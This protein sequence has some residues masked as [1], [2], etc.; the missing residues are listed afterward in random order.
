[1]FNRLNNDGFAIERAAKKSWPWFALALVVGFYQLPAFVGAMWPPRDIISD[2]YQD[3]ASARNFFCG[4]P[5]YSDNREMVGRYVGQVDPVCLCNPVNAHPPTSVLLFA[6]LARLDYR[7]ALLIWNLSSLALLGLSLRL[8]FQGLGVPFSHRTALATFCLLMFCRPL[9]QQLFHGQLNLVLLAL[10]TGA[11]AA[12]RSGRAGW[13]GALVG[14]ATAIKLFPGV[15]FLFLVLRRQWNSLIAGAITVAVLSGLTVAIL[16]LE[17]YRAYIQDVL[18]NLKTFSSSWFNASLVGF[19]SRLFDPDTPVQHVE[20]LWRSAMAA[21]A[22][23]LVSWIAV[24]AVLA[25]NARRAQTRTGLDHAFGS[26]I[27]GMLL[28]SPITWDYAFLLLLVPVAVLWANPPRTERAKILLLTASA[29]LWFWQKPF[30]HI[31][32]P[33]GFLQGMAYPVHSLTVLSYQCYSL[34]VLLILGTMEATG[35]RRSSPATSCHG[36][37]GAPS[38]PPVTAP[39]PFS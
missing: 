30:C 5:I 35:G 29:G 25:R 38:T 11:W 16:G 39:S 15:L 33:G 3:W 34:I 2:F 13:A 27:T 28:L 8:V 36:Q 37:P 12:D 32:I 4:L 31:L 7:P 14:T 24:L 6:P 23:I 21:Q 9:L 1:V 19:W 20:P 22:G 10:L 17:T 18:P 26:A